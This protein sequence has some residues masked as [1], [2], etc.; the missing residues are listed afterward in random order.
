MPSNGRIA[1]MNN[2]LRALTAALRECGS[3]T[4]PMS[5]ALR[6]VEVQRQIRARIDDVNEINKGLV[7]RHG[8]PEE[9]EELAVRVTDQMD[10]WGEYVGAFNDLMRQEMYFDH[11]LV[12]YE[13]EDS[14][15][16]T[17]TG[18]SAIELTANTIF[19][20]G[21]MLKVEKP[22]GTGEDS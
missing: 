11:P 21:D 10:G 6:I 12:L 3:T 18:N 20:L 1:V 16:W 15:G 5:V 2:E 4:V 13:R 14:Y 17:P 8:T 9:G 7:E 19:D 22:E